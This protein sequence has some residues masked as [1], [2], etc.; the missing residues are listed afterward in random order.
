[1]PISSF[2]A[3]CFIISLCSSTPFECL[4]RSHLLSS[5]AN[6]YVATPETRASYSTH[7]L[8]SNVS[9]AL[10]YSLH[11]P[12]ATS[13]HPRRVQRKALIYSLPMSP[14]LS[15]NLFTC[16]QLRR[17]TRDACNVQHSS[18]P[19]RCLP[20]SP[21]LASL[22]NSYVATPETRATYSGM[23]VNEQD[24]WG[25]ITQI[26]AQVG[27]LRALLQ[28]QVCAHKCYHR[29]WWWCCCCVGS[30]GRRC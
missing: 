5:L 4:P 25:T 17:H 9:L 8:P 10:I 16:Q 19:F 22:A 26:D 27:R 12:T 6:S 3:T 11:L 13:P 2:S 18:T 28:A 29:W 24:Y 1:V 14:S 30:I 15:S 23:T 20:R 21:L 7:L